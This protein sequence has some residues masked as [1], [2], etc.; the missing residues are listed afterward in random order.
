MYI[1]DTGI[2]NNVGKKRYLWKQYSGPITK[3]KNIKLFNFVSTKVAINFRG[4]F[5][6]SKQTI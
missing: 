3:T 5:K 6:K 4:I 1:V 2:S